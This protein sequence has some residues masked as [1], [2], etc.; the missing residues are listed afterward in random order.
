MSGLHEIE[1]ARFYFDSNTFNRSE[2]F[3][4]LSTI[5]AGALINILDHAG[6][7]TRMKEDLR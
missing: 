3:I 6:T 5:I 4:A 7:L 2:K 1:L